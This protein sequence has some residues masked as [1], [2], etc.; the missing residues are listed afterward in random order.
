MPTGKKED[1]FLVG[2]LDY[3]KGSIYP[4]ITEITDIR[5]LFV[6]LFFEGI[7]DS[8][9]FLDKWSDSMFP[10]TQGVYQNGHYTKRYQ[11]P[12]CLM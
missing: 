2:H 3:L 12:L 6:D 4:D 8:R 7:R 9:E 10:C 1:K 11:L 5:D